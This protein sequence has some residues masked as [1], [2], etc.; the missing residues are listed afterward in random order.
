MIL[1]ALRNE[2]ALQSQSK[3]PLSQSSVSEQQMNKEESENNQRM[4]FR[5]A[6]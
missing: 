6:A 4:G 1:W 2:I 5:V 3:G